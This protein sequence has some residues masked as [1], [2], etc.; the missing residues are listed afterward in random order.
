MF[1]WQKWESSRIFIII[2]KNAPH[3]N[4]KKKKKKEETWSLDIYLVI[5]ER[6]FMERNIMVSKEIIC[7]GNQKWETEC[8]KICFHK[9]KE[10]EKEEKYDLRRE[11]WWTVKKNDNANGKEKQNGITNDFIQYLTT[12]CSLFNTWIFLLHFRSFFSFFSQFLSHS[13]WYTYS[14]RL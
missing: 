14:E 4:R 12:T 1:L 8:R 6:N 5:R 11:R 13:I 2:Y 10:R 7:I 9:K 3:I